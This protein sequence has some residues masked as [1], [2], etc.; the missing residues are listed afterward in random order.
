[1]EKEVYLKI[2]DYSLRIELDSQLR[3]LIKFNNHNYYLREISLLVHGGKTD[4]TLFVEAF[5]QVFEFDKFVKNLT[6]HLVK[7]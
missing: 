1:M 5:Y 6:V 4:T 2:V 3:N 7:K